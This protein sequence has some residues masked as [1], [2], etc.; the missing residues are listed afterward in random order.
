M[1]G[2][3]CLLFTML[4]TVTVT[5]YN[6]WWCLACV[7]LSAALVTRQPEGD[8]TSVRAKPPPNGLQ[9]RKQPL[10][11]PFLLCFARTVYF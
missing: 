11:S 10:L 7:V 5:V 6:A 1:P 3:R 2:G 9:H 8:G 4:F